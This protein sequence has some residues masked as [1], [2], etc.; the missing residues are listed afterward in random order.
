MQGLLF[1]YRRVL[2]FLA[3]T[4]IPFSGNASATEPIII[5]YAVPSADSHPEDITAGPDGALW[6]TG[7]AVGFAG[8]VGRI[9]TAGVVSGY[10]RPFPPGPPSHTIDITAGPDGA[11]WFTWETFCDDRSG[12]SRITTDGVI[13][14]RY[15]TGSS[16]GILEVAPGTDGAIWVTSPLT[17]RALSG[18]VVRISTDGAV[19]SPFNVGVADDCTGQGTPDAGRYPVGITNGPDGALWFTARYWRL[20]C[21]YIGRITTAGAI[22]NFPI[23]AN[24][25]ATRITAGAD[26][27][28]WYAGGNKIGRITT[29]GVVTEYPIPTPNSGASHITAGPD[30]ALWFTETNAN[31]I[32][33]ITTS[34]QITEYAVPTPDSRVSGI[35]TGPDGA[36]WFTENAANKIGRLTLVPS[37][38]SE[39]AALVRDSNTSGSNPTFTHGQLNSLIA[40]LN[41]AQTSIDNGR[42][43]PA[44]NKIDA[45]IYEVNSLSRGNLFD[46]NAAG[47]IIGG[48]HAVE[49]TLTCAP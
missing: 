22:T 4:V 45:F 13:T 37:T 35:T 32:G 18:N 44:C 5:E 17:P 24:S 48:A 29:D 23:P 21:S 39:L 43:F 30:G 42:I 19:Q 28:L 33:R 15:T 10:T 36:L 16:C 46:S 6:F 3:A 47:S 14:D 38:I 40:K 8:G 12:V 31:K 20:P 34:G 41:S 25:T 11:L 7:Y 1:S 2:L 26:G 49:Q 27:A 9:T